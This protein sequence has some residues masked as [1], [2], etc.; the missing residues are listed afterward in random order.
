MRSKGKIT[1]WNDEKG[2][3]FVTPLAGCKQ[4]F[5]HIRAFSGRNRR[6]QVND[7]VTFALSKDK[8]G[9]PCA[10]DATLAGDK[11]TK[12]EPRK[13]STP[14]II[15]ALLFLGAVGISALA[16][17]VDALVGIAYAVLS[18]IAFAAY[19]FDKSAA[20]RDAWRTPEST[21]HLLSL[22]GGW[23][24]ALIAQQVLRHKSKKVAF[25]AVFWATVLINCAALLWLH[26]DGGQTALESILRP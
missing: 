14:L 24:G 17:R 9:R 15:F 16:G 8:Q 2:Y 20:S 23:P 19:V 7:I 12:K 1:T 3:G 10:A 25:L 4:V 5:I 13:S 26:T 22:V 21:L 18:L 11:L 6:P